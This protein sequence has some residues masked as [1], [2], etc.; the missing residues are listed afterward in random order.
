MRLP[1]LALYTALSLI[2]PLAHAE[3]LPNVNETGLSQSLYS[4]GHATIPG[5]IWEGDESTPN[6]TIEA[7]KNGKPG[8]RVSGKFESKN[9][10]TLLFSSEIIQR[11]QFKDDK[12]NFTVL[13]PL[14][15]KKTPVKVKYI[16]DY[17]NLQE[18]PIEIVYES[19]FQFQLNQAPKKRFT[20]DA[21]ASLT[22]LNF[23]QTST[24]STVNVTQIGLT[25]K[26]G[27]NYH[28][29]ERFD[30]GLSGFA[31]LVG[32]PL[33]KSP[34][35][36]STP[37]FYG[38]NFRLGYRLANLKAGNIY[39]MTGPYV[40]GMIVP[41]SPNGI[42]YGVVKLSGPQIFLVGRF[43]TK[44]ER[45]VVTYLKAASILDGEGG[46]MSNREFAIGGAYQ[47]TPARAAR[48]YMMNFDFANAKFLIQGEEIRLNSVSVGLSTS[49]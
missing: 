29:G 18:Q 10:G 26:L 36:L 21:G 9:A 48:K 17:G 35:G 7:L 6:F 5:L 40:W 22:H 28:L 49:F 30:L 37:R 31:T 38:V 41:A 27:A 39:I 20:I 2:L 12:G 32:L 33:S 13:I 11:A 8:A 47:V 43:L 46:T 3:E 1:V 16:D 23:N 44:S 4:E 14:T 45:T 34:D 15:G 42:N 19:F 24:T 25:P